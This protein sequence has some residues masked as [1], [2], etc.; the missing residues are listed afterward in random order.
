M[1]NGASNAMQMLEAAARAARQ[2]KRRLTLQFVCT[3]NICRSPTAHAIMA[4][5]LMREGLHTA[6]VV[7]SSGTSGHVGWTPDRRSIAAAARR[8]YHNM[9]SLRARALSAGDFD[10]SDLLFALDTGHAKEMRSWRGTTAAQ[11]SKVVLLL[12]FA[13]QHGQDVVD[14][15]YE[16]IGVFDDVVLHIED[17]CNA[18]VAALR[19]VYAAD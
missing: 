4:A 7:T 16:D 3:G 19:T 2:S 18:I 17:A 11:R 5:L 13:P 12:D 8:G 1:S 15:Y 10:E 9:N 6:V 14:P